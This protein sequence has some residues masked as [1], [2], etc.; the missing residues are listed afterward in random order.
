[1]QCSEE[2]RPFSLIAVHSFTLTQRVKEK[3]GLSTERL[4]NATAELAESVQ[5]TERR[6]AELPEEEKKREEEVKQLEQ[7]KETAHAE[8]RRLQGRADEL[9]RTQASLS[10]RDAEVEIERNRLEGLLFEDVPQA[11][12]VAGELQLI[13]EQARAYALTRH[14][15]PFWLAIWAGT[16]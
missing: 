4:W 13:L 5:R 10:E 8:I 6:L 15:F 9:E 11:R 7:Q 2:K 16:S 14:I 12:F 1:M 3:E